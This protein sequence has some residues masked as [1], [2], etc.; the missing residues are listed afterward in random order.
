MVKGFSSRSGIHTM[1]NCPESKCGSNLKKKVFTFG[2]SSQI[3][4][5]LTI[6]G[7]SIMRSTSNFTNIVKAVFFHPQGHL[8]THSFE[9]LNTPIINTRPNSN[10]RGPGHHHLNGMPS[11]RNPPYADNRNFYSFVQIIYTSHG[12]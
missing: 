8:F 7:C 2:D 11:C 5:I 1:T 4:Q 6:R 12:N 10:G 3:S 9:N